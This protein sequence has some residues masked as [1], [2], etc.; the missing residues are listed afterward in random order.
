MNLNQ[1]GFVTPLL[2]VIAVLVIGGGIYYLYSKKISTSVSS[3]SPSIQQTIYHDLKYKFYIT[4]PKTFFDLNLV[5]NDPTG[6]D[7]FTA[8]S[9]DFSTN[10]RGDWSSNDI[11]LTISISKDESANN[12]DGRLKYINKEA[13]DNKNSGIKILESKTITING[14][15]STQLL[16]TYPYSITDLSGCVFETFFKIN[17]VSHE[18]E[19][20]SDTCDT[21]TSHRQEY[22]TIVKSFHY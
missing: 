1:R 14:V 8:Y 4:L 9:K 6:G 7:N 22:E 16:V 10:A 12:I 13:G 15:P 20:Q 21:T 19:L 5:R 3:L 11:G 2:I 17:G 18:I